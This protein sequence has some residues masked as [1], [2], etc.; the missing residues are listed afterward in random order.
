MKAER[1]SALPVVYLHN[2]INRNNYR[3]IEAMADLARRTGCDCI[4]YSPFQTLFGALDEFSLS[5]LEMRRTVQA[6]ERTKRRLRTLST[7]HNID[8]VL[9][10]YRVGTSVWKKLPCY[11][12]WYNFRVKVDGTVI[13]CSRCDIVIGNLQNETMEEVWNSPAARE[14]RKKASTLKGIESMGK[15]CDCSYCCHVAHNMRIHRIFR[16]LSPVRLGP[17]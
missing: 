10:R 14:F 4:A 17:R 12:A 1:K 9:L 7:G 15:E 16:W 6:L 13:P 8:E 5:G 11:A 3:S 2:V